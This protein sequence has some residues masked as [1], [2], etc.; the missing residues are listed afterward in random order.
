MAY[1]SVGFHELLDF[2][3]YDTISASATMAAAQRWES[4]GDSGDTPFTATAA[5]EGP[6]AAGTNRAASGDDHLVEIAHRYLCWQAQWGVLEIEVMMQL[7]VITTIAFNIGFNDDTG[8]ASNTLPAELGGVAWA[9][10]AANFMGFVFDTDATNDEIHV[11]WSG[12]SMD[13]SVPIASLRMNE[14]APTA[15]EWAIYKVALVEQGSGNGVRATFSFIDHNGRLWQKEFDTN[16]DREELL[17]P[18]VAFEARGDTTHAMW[19][20]YI[21]VRQSLPA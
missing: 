6:Y 3:D 18:Y 14:A 17:T 5:S 7:N 8:E 4:E 11:F 21:H 19:L 12:D 9:S 16:I 2:F 15:G 1:G 13:A 10:N 20:K